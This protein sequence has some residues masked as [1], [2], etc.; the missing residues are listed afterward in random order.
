M[1]RALPLVLV[2]VAGCAGQDAAPLEPAAARAE[3]LTPVQHLVRAS[4]AL[5]GVRPSLDELAAVQED[6]AWLA[7][8]VDT[9]LDSPQFGAT[10]REMHA[11]Q[12]LIGVDA[13]F[14][15][16]GFPARDELAGME[17]QALNERIVEAPLRLIEHVVMEDRPYHEI[18]TADYTV[19]DRVTATV[20]GIPYDDAGPE[21]QVTRYDDG[22]P[23]A[24]I[25]SD[26]F[27]YTRHSSTF[28]N[29]NR[30]R[31][32]TISRSLLCYDFL[33]R[34]V[35]IDTSIDLGDD[36]A[37]A[38][39]IRENHA[40]AS[41]HQTLD[42]LAAH[43][44][45]IFPLYVPFQIETYP[46]EVWE[47]PYA[48]IMRTTAPGFFGTHSSGLRDLGV[49]VASDPRFALCTSRRFFSYLAQVEPDAVSYETVDQLD[50]VFLNSGMS[51]KELARAVVFSEAFTAARASDRQTDEEAES[52]RGLMK[53]RPEQLARMV[54]DLT[55]YRW[56]TSL[57]F[58]YGIGRIGRIDLMTDSFFG[59]EVL[60]GGTDAQSVSRPAHTQTSTS[61][62]VMR[63]LAAHA[64]PAAL[65]TIDAGLTEEAAVRAQLVRLQLRWLGE[66]HEPTDPAVDEA[67]T[68]WSGAYAESGD[69]T[70]AWTVTLYALLQDVRIAYY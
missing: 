64:A 50:T 65:G 3:P 40:C 46:F 52:V 49:L 26:S 47:N 8:I 15:P 60:A 13:A 63:A 31:A 34:Q 22:R 14:Y 28:S 18:V 29:R 41:C 21:W 67:W 38:N 27:L 42:P 59:F 44:S 36:E 69:A 20:F 70:R 54:E 53:A 62:L 30:G 68:L 2:L 61:A 6:P 19:A 24:G 10:V 66:T 37:V 16:A 58:D 17:V 23:H 32:A 11:E 4:M 51:A 56:Q 55:G 25:L 35:E 39:A 48:G 1:S 9:Y 57:A 5:R 12:F 33:S 7:P 43:F 45:E